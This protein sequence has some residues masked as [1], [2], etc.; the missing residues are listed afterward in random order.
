MDLAAHGAAPF[1]RGA[2]FFFVILLP[3]ATPRP[4]R[5]CLAVPGQS[6]ALELWD[7]LFTPTLDVGAGVVKTI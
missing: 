3:P 6:L 7:G 1:G 4:S 5:L 2:S